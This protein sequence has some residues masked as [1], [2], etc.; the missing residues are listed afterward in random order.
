M[1]N[2]KG[3]IILDLKGYIQCLL[4]LNLKQ[5]SYNLNIQWKCHKL[6]V[7][8]CYSWVW[9][10]AWS[11]AI[12]ECYSQSLHLMCFAALFIW[13][14]RILSI[15]NFGSWLS[16]SFKKKLSRFCKMYVNNKRHCHPQRSVVHRM[17]TW[18]CSKYFIKIGKGLVHLMNTFMNQR[19][20]FLSS[21]LLAE[22]L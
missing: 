22:F 12:M 19:G 6:Q 20:A 15:R 3:I 7:K 14:T 1:Q 5:I 9:T 21:S 4:R 16:T 11:G 13:D 17:Y 2:T 8:E 10:L 18:A